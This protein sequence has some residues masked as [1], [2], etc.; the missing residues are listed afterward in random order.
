MRPIFAILLMGLHLLL[1]G[2]T[3]ADRYW[4]LG[5]DSKPIILDFGQDTLGMVYPSP[6]VDYFHSPLIMSEGLS[7]I[8]DS[9]GPLISC[10]GVKICGRMGHLIPEGDTLLSPQVYAW[11]HLIGLGAFQNTIV[12]PR[13]DSTFY[14]FYLDITDSNVIKK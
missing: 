12:L 2:Q 1:Q 3:E 9:L 4:Y 13:N 14:V 7:M 5:G 6:M 8:S 10:D 11:R